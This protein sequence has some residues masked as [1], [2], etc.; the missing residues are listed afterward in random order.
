MLKAIQLGQQLTK[1]EMKNVMGGGTCCYHNQGWTE[2]E[3][4]NGC[5]LAESKKEA[6][7]HAIATGNRWFY[8]CAN[9]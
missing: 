6:T 7:K 5:T 2:Y 4:C 8:C 3:C 1:K 9:C